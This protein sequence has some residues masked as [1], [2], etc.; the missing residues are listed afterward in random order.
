MVESEKQNFLWNFFNTKHNCR[1]GLKA[2]WETELCRKWDFILVKVKF[3]MFFKCGAQFW[4]SVSVSSGNFGQT[5]IKG[6]GSLIACPCTSI[7]SIFFQS[8]C[9]CSLIVCCFGF[10][11]VL[12]SDVSVDNTCLYLNNRSV[13][14]PVKLDV[15][16]L[17][18]KRF[19]NS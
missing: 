13:I 15:L 1:L 3:M 7:M 17:T 10:L 18:P 11:V 2:Y 19:N 14:H 8:L 4:S 5:V 12:D 16:P 6:L 9:T